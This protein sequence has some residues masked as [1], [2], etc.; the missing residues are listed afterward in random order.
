M[1]FFC[2]NN[3][4]YIILLASHWTVRSQAAAI[5]KND[6]IK[7]EAINFQ[8][9]AIITTGVFSVWEMNQNNC[10]VNSNRNWKLTAT[11]FFGFLSKWPIK[12]WNKSKLLVEGE[13]QWIYQKVTKH[14]T[15]MKLYVE[16]C[17]SRVNSTNN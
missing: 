12:L 15:C 4:P 16:Y 13:A 10:D 8:V 2:M 6:Q 3:L 1:I 14:S 17:D 11:F 5:N 9:N 7:T